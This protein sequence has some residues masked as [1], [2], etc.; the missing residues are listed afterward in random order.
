M[1]IRDLT[2]AIS[3]SYKSVYAKA[4]QLRS[5]GLVEKG[6]NDLWRLSPGVTP[7]SLDTGK[8]TRLVR[9]SEPASSEI[10][11]M[12][13]IDSETTIA[14]QIPSPGAI[15][16]QRHDF[17]MRLV[18]VGVRPKEVTSTI[19]DIFFSGDINNLTWL[20]SVLSRD[21]GGY[22]LPHQRRLIFSWWARTRGLL[23]ADEDLPGDESFWKK[24]NDAGEKTNPHA[25]DRPPDVGLGWIVDKNKRGVWIPMPGGPLTYD[26]ALDHANRRN[27]L[28][29]RRC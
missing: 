10:E 2:Q 24:P 8:S 21:A 4:L 14:D 7:L 28:Q 25:L 9:N 23:Y 3:F 15:L 18:A 16:D 22:I 17:I 20:D 5:M 29:R 1:P 26:Q 27:L 12:P 6:N 19:A 13:V 11:S